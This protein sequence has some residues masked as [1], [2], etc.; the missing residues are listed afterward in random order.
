[1][2][3]GSLMNMLDGRALVALRREVTR[4]GWQDDADFNASQIADGLARSDAALFELDGRV[5]WIYE[6]QIVPVTGAVLS[7]LVD[8][9]LAVPVLVNRGTTDA[10]TWVLEPQ[11]LN[12]PRAADVFRRVL[13][14]KTL[15]EG[16]LIFRL[17]RIQM[18]AP[19]ARA[20]AVG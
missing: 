14:G 2:K 1:M 20:A 8:R 17:S 12:C 15:G 11:P 19:E 6:G 9:Y 18:P 16:G 4:A 10:P 13:T 5:V 7:E 3:A